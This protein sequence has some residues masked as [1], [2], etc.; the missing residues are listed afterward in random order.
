MD[1]FF[2]TTDSQCTPMGMYEIV[3]WLQKGKRIF[4]HN[5]EWMMR[6]VRASTGNRTIV[7]A[8]EID[9]NILIQRGLIRKVGV[10]L[11]LTENT[12]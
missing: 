5:G 12:R 11:V 8:D 3:Y 6:L 7:Y 1:F 10:A 4:F 9:V 2:R